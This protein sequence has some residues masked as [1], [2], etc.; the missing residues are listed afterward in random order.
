MLVECSRTGVTLGTRVVFVCKIL[1]VACA[2][3][4]GDSIVSRMASRAARLSRLFVNMERKWDGGL[5]GHRLGHGGLHGEGNLGVRL[6]RH[7]VAQEQN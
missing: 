6:E 4:Q 1:L 2:L 7:E 3:Y 5:R